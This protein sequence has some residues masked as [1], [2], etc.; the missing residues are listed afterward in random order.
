MLKR[1]CVCVCVYV[2]VCMYL[3][4]HTVGDIGPLLGVL[5]QLAGNQLQHNAELGIVGGVGVGE[6]AVLGVELL[7]LVALVDEPVGV[8][9]CEFVSTEICMYMHQSKKKKTGHQHTH[10]HTHTDTQ[11]QTRTRSYPRRHP[12]S[13]RVRRP[14]HRQWAR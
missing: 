7:G 3:P 13:S 9:V 5:G 4:E 12:Q 14:S 6:G 2:C 1:V 10:T 11:T 8:G